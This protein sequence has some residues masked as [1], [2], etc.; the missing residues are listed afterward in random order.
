VKFVIP[1]EAEIQKKCLYVHQYTTYGKSETFRKMDSRF[2]RNDQLTFFS[3]S[4]A[5]MRAYVGLPLLVSAFGY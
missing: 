5:F 1:A 4:S 2:H 3:L